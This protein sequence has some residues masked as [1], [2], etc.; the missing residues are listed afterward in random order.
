MTISN[1]TDLFDNVNMAPVS[2]HLRMLILKQEK[3]IRIMLYFSELMVLVWGMKGLMIQKLV[4]WLDGTSS[5]CKR[6]MKHETT[7]TDLK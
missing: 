5:I 6:L 2:D 4:I 1:E 7:E 3:E